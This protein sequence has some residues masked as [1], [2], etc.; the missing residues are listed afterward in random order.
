MLGCCLAAQIHLMRACL[1]GSIACSLAA[2]GFPVWPG[3]YQ[4]LHSC[5]QQQL[6]QLQRCCSRFCG[7]VYVYTAASSRQSPTNPR[8]L[9]SLALTLAARCHP[10]CNLCCV[11]CACLC[12]PSLLCAV[13]YVHPCFVMY[14][15]FVCHPLIVHC[16][17]PIAVAV[18]GQKVLTQTLSQPTMRR[19]FTLQPCEYLCR[20]MRRVCVLATCI[21]MYVQVGVGGW[22]L[23]TS[24]RNSRWHSIYVPLQPTS[25]HDSGAHSFLQL[26]LALL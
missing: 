12:R 16:C 5:H 23:V 7:H 24:C 10:L 9:N 3:K 21:R 20:A 17:L 15:A 19:G 11:Q 6:P 1:P 18:A 25:P 13:F 2:A 22:G 26:P 14:H 4:A 8:I